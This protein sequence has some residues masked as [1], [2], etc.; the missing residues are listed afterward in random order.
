MTDLRTPCIVALYPAGRRSR[1]SC[2]VH[3][4]PT[5]SSVVM[6]RR[7]ADGASRGSAVR[8]GRSR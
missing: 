2:N 3:T 5:D 4:I 6:L 7:C 8:A 1:S